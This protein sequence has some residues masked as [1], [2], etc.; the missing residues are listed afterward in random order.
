MKYGTSIA[1]SLFLVWLLWSGHYTLD[2]TLLTVLGIA[3]CILVAIIAVRMKVVDRE[4]HPIHLLGRGLIYL[5]WLLWA[6]VKA[7][8]DVTR[9]ILSPSLPISPTLID[10]QATQKSALGQVIYAN[11]I[12]L[13]PGTVTID[14]ID[15]TLTVH[16][17][18]R[19]GAHELTE[20]DMDRK[21]TAL[22]GAPQQDTT[23]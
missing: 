15:G 9:R 23:S 8:L 2:S 22:E 12:T 1:I 6:I 18:S 5:P 21:V 11:S 4:G 10:V 17:L 3:S 13:T 20:G 16:A 7:N 19:E 14:A